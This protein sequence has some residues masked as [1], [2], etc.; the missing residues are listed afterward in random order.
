M[1]LRASK[2][3][4]GGGGFIREVSSLLAAHQPMASQPLARWAITAYTWARGL[5]YFL[6]RQPQNPET[7]PHLA[8]FEPVYQTLTAEYMKPPGVST[9]SYTFPPLDAPTSFPKR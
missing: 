6:F 9:Q 7:A 3:L 2:D 5:T 4:D 1:S 8:L